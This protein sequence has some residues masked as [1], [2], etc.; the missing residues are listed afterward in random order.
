M[1]IGS[2]QTNG[3]K[4]Y[5]DARWLLVALLCTLGVLGLTHIPP[6][7]M[8][9]L[10]RVHLSDKLGHFLAYGLITMSF[11]GALKRQAGWRL[12]LTVLVGIAILGIFDEVTQPLVSRQASVGDFA[13][14]VA[15]ILAV[16]AL[17]ISRRLCNPGNSR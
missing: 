6:Q 10:P 14:D 2:L 9:Q 15:G 12:R 16:T 13:A 4:S 3:L 8:P 7:F 11:I 5:V 17:W 1:N